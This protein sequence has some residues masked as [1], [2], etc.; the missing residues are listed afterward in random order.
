MEGMCQI[1]LLARLNSVKKIERFLWKK[2]VCLDNIHTHRI[3]NNPA[4][5]LGFSNKNIQTP[6]YFHT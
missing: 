1:L 3:L 5:F 2:V 6:L 4:T